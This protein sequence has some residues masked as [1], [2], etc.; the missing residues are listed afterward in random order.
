[1]DRILP[2][3]VDQSTQQPQQHAMR[4]HLQ[5]GQ[6]L[7]AP[8]ASHAQPTVSDC[9]SMPIGS[10]AMGTSCCAETRPVEDKLTIAVRTNNTGQRMIPPPP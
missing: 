4:E 9:A 6:A 7:H 3:T 1:M 5:L 10:G 8:E 2:G